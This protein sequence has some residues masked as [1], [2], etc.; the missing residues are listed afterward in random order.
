MGI[1]KYLRFS[2][3]HNGWWWNCLTDSDHTQKTLKRWRYVFLWT[4]LLL[5]FY[6]VCLTYFF[7]SIDD[8]KRSWVWSKRVTPLPST[9]GMIR[10]SPRAISGSSE[11]LLS[12]SDMPS[13]SHKVLWISGSFYMLDSLTFPRQIDAHG[14]GWTHTKHANVT[15]LGPLSSKTGS[16]ILSHY[17]KQGTPS[18]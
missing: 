10:R 14:Y 7:C 16:R 17:F 8:H 12:I 18:R 11:M 5:K 4:E 13:T 2:R 6:Y 3:I 1:S 9:K 15:Q